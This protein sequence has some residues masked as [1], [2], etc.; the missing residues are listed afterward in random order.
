[1]DFRLLEQ[2]DV[3]DQRPRPGSRWPPLRCNACTF[4]ELWLIPLRH[5]RSSTHSKT[6]TRWS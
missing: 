3:D 6:K 5:V 2:A 1:M 4:I